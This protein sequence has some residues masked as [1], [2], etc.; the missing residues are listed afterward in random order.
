MSRRE[1]RSLQPELDVLS[2]FE[3]FKK[4]CLLANKHIAKINATLSV[5]INELTVQIT[6][7]QV[8][9]AH[10]RSREISLIG[11]VK[12]EKEVSRRI[13]D[14]AENAATG[15]FAAL[16]TNFD[17]IRGASPTPPRRSIA[18]CIPSSPSS[19]VRIARAP[20]EPGIYEEEEPWP[21][22]S[23][24]LQSRGSD[25]RQ[26]RTGQPPRVVNDHQLETKSRK[27]RLSASKL[28]IP[29]RGSSPVP[30]RPSSPIPVP[31]RMLSPPLQHMDPSPPLRQIHFTK[32]VDLTTVTKKPLRRQSGLITRVEQQDM[33]DVVVHKDKVILDPRKQEEKEKEK[34]RAKATE[35]ARA[36]EE[37]GSSKKS[38][39]TDVTNGCQLKTNSKSVDEMNSGTKRKALLPVDNVEGPT[40]AFLSS[41]PPR[42]THL[43]SPPRTN[44]ASPSP[45]TD[46]SPSP[47]SDRQARADGAARE[48]E[49]GGE[50]EG[51]A[52][53]GR[54]RR[55]RKSVNYAEPKLNTKMRKPDGASG[56]SRPKKRASAAA[57]L[58]EPS[59]AGPG[60][61]RH[62]SAHPEGRHDRPDDETDEPRSSAE[63]PSRVDEFLS[64]IDPSTFPLP[65]SRP[66]SAMSR[67]KSPSR[68]SPR[69]RKTRPY[70]LPS[71]DEEEDDGDE[72]DAEYVPKGIGAGLWV[73]VDARRGHGVG[74]TKVG[75]SKRAA[76]DMFDERDRFELDD[77]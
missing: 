15:I 35:D 27:A 13:L 69:R 7:L 57:V 36:K 56:T 60:K 52:A 62:H 1:S 24:E 72:A 43:P 39:F 5:R 33:E 12:R 47:E 21:S 28:P 63:F 37:A 22:S 65:P 38:K 9:N 51:S 53:E 25:G 73:N 34:R 32:P 6:L 2:E 58:Y 40:G 75:S 67:P 54:Q 49:V 29:T 8:E 68:V 50:S 10:L 71:D 61:E 44:P 77:V 46:G 30:Q 18:P 17:C 48:E 55:V 11:Q 41:S 42:T 14:E 70:V 59:G 19:I 4:K 20:N 26:A 31:P 45:T 64:H 3:A 76:S 66:S 23:D 74:K 16:R